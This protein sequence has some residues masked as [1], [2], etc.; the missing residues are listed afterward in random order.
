M[1]TFLW[2]FAALFTGTVALFGTLSAAMM[3]LTRVIGEARLRRWLGGGPVAAPLKGLVFGVLTPFCS[4]STIPVLTSLLRARVRTSAV[5]AF[6]L[7]SPVLDP[8]LV[9]ALGW[10]LGLWIAVWFTVFLTIATVVLAVLAE[11][12]HLERLV[13]AR[14]LVPV[15]V[16]AAHETGVGCG[17]PPEAAWRGWATEGV[18]AVRD[19]GKQMRQLLVP[20]ALTCAIGVAIAGAVPEQLVLDHAGPGRPFA[21][22]AAAVLGVPLYLPTEA[23]APIGWAMRDAGVSAGAI[24]AFMVTAASLSLPEFFLLTHVFRLRLVVGVVLAVLAIAVIGALV[25]PLLLG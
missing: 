2:H 19:A 13:L 7:A 16:P 9:I 8:V 3:L 25:V 4:W 23:L 15:G 12:F 21:I 1:S 5:A 17:V 18:D 20:L 22:P 11:R 14:A 24:F 10:L 6:F